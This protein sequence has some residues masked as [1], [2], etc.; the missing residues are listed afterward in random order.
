MTV[1]DEQL[2]KEHNC[3]L[4]LLIPYNS[5]SIYTKLKN[6]NTDRKNPVLT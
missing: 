2:L 5:I 1:T 3:L 6:D 4:K